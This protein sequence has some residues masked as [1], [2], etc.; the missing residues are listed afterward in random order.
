MADVKHLLDE[1]IQFFNEGKLDE[2]IAKFKEALEADSANVQAHS[3]LGAAFA[4][5]K[6]YPSAIEQF[7]A[8][9][10]LAPENATHLFNLGQA[11]ETAGN[12]PQA[13]VIY[14][15]ALSIDPKYARARQCL[16]ALTGRPIAPAPKPAAPVQPPTQTVS[17]PSAPPPA[18]T[19]A[20][21]PYQPP[22]SPIAPPYGNTGPGYTQTP[23]VIHPE[24]RL[25][26]GA[27]IW[28]VILLLLCCSPIG[29]IYMWLK[30]DWSNGVKWGVTIAWLVL[31]GLNIIARL[32]MP[33][34][35]K[36]PGTIIIHPF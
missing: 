16:E 2:A 17:M 24:V 11:Y 10:D 31:M 28:L 7:K 32:S 30:S 20:M 29:V 19:Q 3:Y 21:P 5:E 22:T 27:P 35:P 26:D 23:R 14:E 12:K 1:G 8:A 36:I 9:V 33:T 4:R 18:P 13:Q 6:E 25:T 15:K 34:T